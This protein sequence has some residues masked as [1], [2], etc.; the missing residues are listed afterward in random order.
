MYIMD[1]KDKY[2]ACMILFTVGDVVG[3]KSKQWKLADQ[4][5]L[6]SDDYKYTYELLFKYIDDG[7]IFGIDLSNKVSSVTILNKIIANV[8]LNKTERFDD[9]ID[10]F[11]IKLKDAITDEDTK[12]RWFDSKIIENINK[13]GKGV[14]WDKI[15]Y[16]KTEIFSNVG[17]G[18]IPVGMILNKVEDVIQ[19]SIEFG[20]ILH[21]NC[22]SYL[23]FLTISL[24][25]HYAI[26]DKQI[27]TW[28]YR[29]IKILESPKLDEYFKK[30][31]D[32]ENFLSCKEK[33]IN[34]WK[35]YMHDKFKQDKMLQPKQPMMTNLKLRMK[36]YIEKFGPRYYESILEERQASY[37][38]GNSGI[39]AT[40]MI[41]DCIVDS[42]INWETLIIYSAIHYGNSNVIGATCAGLYGLLYG[43]SNVPKYD[44]ENLEFFSE[45]KGIGKSIHSTK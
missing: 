44:L 33:F 25:A 20:R 28:P 41:Y 23:G 39:D 43:F 34:N 15:Q 35:R 36:Y 42:G 18:A 9:N 2:N 32:H 30:T 17:C 31:R 40:I 45:L 21:N 14:K 12:K 10:S 38:P 4:S 24:F 27:I 26:K 29:L 7:G 11:I 5:H 6:E 22:L 37:L 16:D 13:I 19:Y 8:M 3:F 1:V